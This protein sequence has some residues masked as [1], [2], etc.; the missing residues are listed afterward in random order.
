MLQ[1]RIA[2]ER[3]ICYMLGVH[4]NVPPFNNCNNNNNVFDSYEY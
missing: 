1:C 4:N 3:P 2:Q